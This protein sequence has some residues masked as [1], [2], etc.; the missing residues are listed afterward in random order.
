M[1]TLEEFSNLVADIYDAALDPALWAQTL[2]RVFSVAGGNNAALV[3]YDRE[4]RRRPHI[5][6]ANFDPYKIVS[7]TSTIAN[8]IPSPLFWNEVALA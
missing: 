8:S 1:A 3:V 6:A 4:K 2:K 7:T 5:I